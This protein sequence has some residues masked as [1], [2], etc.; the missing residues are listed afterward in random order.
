MH[1]S[2]FIII[3]IYFHLCK[4]FI[5]KLKNYKWAKHFVI[6]HLMKYFNHTRIHKT[7]PFNN[8]TV[9]NCSLRNQK[10][11]FLHFANRFCCLIFTKSMHIE[12]YR[13]LQKYGNYEFL[14]RLGHNSFA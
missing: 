13:Y 3:S 5:L 12:V 9:L 1:V 11:I 6:N 2:V 10:R 8:E 14:G 7:K 4:N